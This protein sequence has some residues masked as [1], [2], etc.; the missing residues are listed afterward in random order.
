MTLLQAVFGL[1]KFCVFLVFCRKAS[2]N[3][4]KAMLEKIVRAIMMFFDYNYVGNI[5]NRFSY[6]M[7]NIDEN[8]PFIFPEFV[9]VSIQVVQ[10]L[11]LD[12]T[13]D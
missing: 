8:L 1:I 6:D 3:I 5:L 10:Y 4:H 12:I 2:I 7:N 13:F 9:G 11:H